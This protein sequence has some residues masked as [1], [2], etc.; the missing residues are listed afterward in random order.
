MTITA[1]PD[2]EDTWSTRPPV[3]TVLAVVHNVTAAT[4]L[5]DVLSLIGADDRIRI[6]FTIT[7]SS[8]FHDGTLDYLATRGVRQ[9]TW[10]DAIATPFDMAISASYG[11]DLHL[12]DAPFMVVPHGMGYNKYLK[13][14]N[15][16]I[17]FRIVPR[18][19]G[20]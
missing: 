6:V 8:A 17:R 14:G 13:S 15:R 1:A 20:T 18:M 10:T 2:S 11:G 3:R 9:L 7:G 16:E 4:R 19:A 12:L 5:F